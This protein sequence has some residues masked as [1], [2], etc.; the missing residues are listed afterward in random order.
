MAVIRINNWKVKVRLE[1][2]VCL[3]IMLIAISLYA[4]ASLYILGKYEE[5][6]GFSLFTN[7]LALVGAF[8]ASLEIS[9]EKEAK[10]TA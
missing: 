6:L 3:F 4:G 5:T 7:L 10:Q 2:F 8:I 1:L 9:R